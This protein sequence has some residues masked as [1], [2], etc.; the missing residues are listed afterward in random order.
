MF[1]PDR[2]PRNLKADAVSVYALKEVE[3]H[4]GDRI[5]WT[6]NDH[7]RELLNAQLAPVK[8][9]GAEAITVSSLADGTVH[10]LARSD[11]MLERLDLAY[12]LNVHAAQG[13]TTKHG[14]VMMSARDGQLASQSTSS[15]PSRGL[16]TA[17]RWSSIAAAISSGRCYALLATRPLPLM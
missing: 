1:L 5:R 3:L 15:S 16:P 10:E 17:R 6:G 11:R 4:A 8:K 13:V 7:G 14:I 2:L 12:A 9:V